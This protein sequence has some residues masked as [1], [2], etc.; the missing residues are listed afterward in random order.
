MKNMKRIATALIVGTM[1][2]ASAFAQSWIDVTSTYLKNAD[3]SAG[4]WDGWTVNYNNNNSTGGPR[5]DYGAMELWYCSFRM[6]QT[7]SVPNGRYRVSVQAFYRT[8]ALEQAYSSYE[9][10]METIPAKLFAGQQQVT[11]KSIFA[12]SRT[13]QDGEGTWSSAINDPGGGW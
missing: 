2:M 1:Y 9:A 5:C 11:L 7:L 6:S 12:E 3:F 13:D 10:N 4:N 8:Q